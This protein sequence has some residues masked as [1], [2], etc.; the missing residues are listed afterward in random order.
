MCHRVVLAALVAVTAATVPTVAQDAARPAFRDGIAT[1]PDAPL[2]ASSAADLPVDPELFYKLFVGADFHSLDFR[3]PLVFRSGTGGAVSSNTGSAYAEVGV[4]LPDSTVVREVTFIYRNCG[5][6]SVVPRYYFGM[7]TPGL[8]AFTYHVP[9]TE[10]ELGRLD[11]RPFVD[12]V[13]IDPPV[14]VHNSQNR[15]VAGFWFSALGTN[16]VQQLVGVRI[17]YS[18]R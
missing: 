8:A 13:T 14:D 9:E 6:A 1:S 15:Y 16:T 12:R 10:G 18:S 2:D 4:D 3:N 17:G 7:Y 5:V 11:C